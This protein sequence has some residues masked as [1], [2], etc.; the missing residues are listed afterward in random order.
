MKMSLRTLFTLLSISSLVPAAKAQLVAPDCFLQGNYVEVGINPNAGFGSAGAAPAGYHPNVPMTG[1]ALGF[2]AD[3]EKDGW[4]VSIAAAPQYMGDYFVPGTPY[5]GWEIQA[6]GAAKG[7]GWGRAGGPTGITG[8]NVSYTTSATQSV[9]V[10]QGTYGNLAIT[11]TT[12]LKKDKVYFV[13]NVDIVNMGT[14]PIPNIYYFRGVDPDN[15]EAWTGAPGFITDNEIVFQPNAT[16][17]NCLVSATGQGFPYMSYLGLGTKDCRAKCMNLPAWHPAALSEAYTGLGSG[18]GFQYTVGWRGAGDQA[19]GVVWNLGTLDPGQKT[20]LAYTYILKK[21]DLDSALEETAP[22]FVSD[23]TPFAPFTTF[24]V[25][26]GNTIPLK[27]I[28]GGQYKWIWTPSTNMNPV[29]GTTIVG[30]GGTLPTITGSYAYPNG[31]AQGDSISVNVFGPMEYRATGISNCD[32]QVLVFYVDTI[33]FSVPPAVTTPVRYCE[34][35]AATT[36]TAGAATGAILRWYNDPTGGTPVAAPTPATTFPAGAVTDY[37]TTSYYVS[38]VN[39]AGCETPRA[40]IDVIITRKPAPPVVS[41][42]V[43]CKDMPAAPLTAV[44]ASLKWYDAAT[45]G[46]RY[47]TTPTPLTATPGQVSYFVSQTVNGCES[48]RAQLDVE[49]STIVAA[50]DML[51][52]SLCGAELNMFYNRTVS[53]ALLDTNYHSVWTFGDGTPADTFKDANHTYADAS[54]VY[55]V[56]L[57]VTNVYG[58]SDSIT[59]LLYAFPQPYMSLTASDTVICQGDVIDFHGTGSAGYSGLSWDFGDNDPAYDALDV[60]HAF[61]QP[62]RFDVQIKGNYP[63]CPDITASVPVNIIPIPVVNLGPDT[64]LCT[65]SATIVLSN[66]SGVSAAHY[67]WSTG[68]TTATISVNHDGSYWLRASNEDC[69]ATDSINIVKSCYLDIPNAFTPG[70]GSDDNGY[71]LPRQLLSRS[72]ITFDMKIFDRWGQLLFESD[73]VDGRG[74][75][76]NFKDKPMPMGVYVYQIKVSYA[77]GVTESYQGNIT[78]IR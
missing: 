6:N 21:Q 65:G 56:G 58:C 16:S 7:L 22:K 2:V 78:L 74:W 60:R 72:V 38:Q 40:R 66:R 17:T 30:P 71:F 67:L 4:L 59:H 57:K 10:W 64:I 50:F 5:E 25:C 70:G 18:A 68:D 13:I 1:N 69:S 23:G 77:N 47:V 27:I 26:P 39:A 37:D 19:I 34:G 48:D 61:A 63:A 33:S 28:N 55:T 32:T 73:K 49:T 45:A 43:Y 53:T 31:A 54:T 35:D 20:T 8:A 36:L 14:T 62:G 52:D 12:T 3:P 15:E 76:G 41:S 9:G 51:H 29:A 46:T 44:G 42:L 24:R 75:D 11:Q